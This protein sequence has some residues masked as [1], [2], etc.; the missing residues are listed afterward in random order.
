MKRS[1]LLA[2]SAAFLYP[3]AVEAQNRIVIPDTEEYLILTGDMHVHTV[4][5]DGSVWPTTRVE[6]AFAEGVEVICM[7]DHLDDRHRRLLKNGDFNRDRNYSYDVAVKRGDELGII[8]VKGAEISRGMPPG[9]FNTL[10]I[11][12]VEPIAQAS[13][14]HEDHQE[15]MLAGLSQAVKQNAFCV[16]NHPHWSA[17]QPAEVLWHPEHDT[18]F[19]KGYMHAIEV[20]NSCDG[21][22]FEAFQWALDRNLTLI[23]GTDV[24]GPMFT[25]YNFPAGELRPVTLIFAKEASVNGVREALEARRT[26]V[27]ADG[28]VYGDEKLLTMLLDA[29]LRVEAVRQQGKNTMV[30]LKSFSSIPLR[31]RRNDSSPDAAY[32]RFKVVYPFETQV[33]GCRGLVYKTPIVKE[34]FIMSFDVENFYTAPG[35]NLNYKIKINR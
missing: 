6:E 29:C 19:N 28:C 3:V 21:F 30:T 5:S 22:S 15:G 1:L 2:L 4:F 7:T 12:D 33:Y 17:Q 9:H 26:A 32:S 34:E 20:Y 25:E 8:V 18:I 27:F 14:A 31:L 35:K 16:W 10:F 23:C 11:S 13:D 24:H